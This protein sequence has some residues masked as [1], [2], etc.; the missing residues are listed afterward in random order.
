MSARVAVGESD[1][2]LRLTL[3]HNCIVDI[4]ENREP[5]AGCLHSL[6]AKHDAGEIEV[7][8][9]ATSA[10]ERQRSGPYLANFS[11]FQARIEALGLGHLPVLRPILLLDVSDLD[12]AI[13]AGP[14]DIA[15]LER[16]HGV[17]FPGQ[18]YD[19]QDALVTTEG[20]ADP[21]KAHQ[22]WRN[23]QLDVHVLW[24]H[25]H[26][27]GDIFVTSDTDFFKKQAALAKL[28]ATR[29]LRPCEAA[30]L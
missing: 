1:A 26:Y 22:K 5:K 3:D 10:S 16:I 20:Q 9:V 13:L 11:E 19:L 7:R 2:V 14:E 21:E 17:L 12:R 24:C 4:D 27:G 25:L 8:L 30:R 28:G 23:R 18:S 15:L 6:V 29:I